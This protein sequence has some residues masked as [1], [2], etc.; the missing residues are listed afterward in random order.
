MTNRAFHFIPVLAALHNPAALEALIARYTPALHALGGQRQDAPDP[1]ADLPH[2][3]F[4]VT[5]GT[6]QRLL[7]LWAQRH[8]IHP[9]EP[10]LLLA[11]P[12]HNALPAAL[13]ILAHLQQ[14][15][16]PGRI[17]YLGGPED[18][19]GLAELAAALDDLAVWRALHQARI[20][21]VGPPSDWLVASSPAPQ[22][23]TDTWGPAVAPLPLERL[24]ALAAHFP[25]EEVAAL[26]EELAAQASATCEPQPADLAAVVRIYLALRELAAAE[27]LTALTLRCFDLVLDH[28]TTGCFALAELNDAGLIAGCEGDLVSTLGMVWAY[29][30]LG[31]LPWMANPARLDVAA[32]T[33]WLAHCTVPRRLVQRYRLRS[34]FE[35][36]LGVGLQGELAPGPV[37]L[38]R[39][40]GAHLRKLWLAEGELLHS[41]NAEDLCRTQAEIQLTRGQ[42][43][44]LLTEPLGNHLVLV[45]GHHAERLH[46]WHRAFIAPQTED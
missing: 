7:D 27:K 20:G 5:G 6:E 45:P 42:V 21:L 38:L 25:T 36:G 32:N 11:H 40:G 16:I 12:G 43:R 31:T 2:L 14:R 1:A 3:Y 29:E 44:E 15:H 39:I 41:G 33:L 13:E 46:H 9:D 37:T 18:S 8:A 34:H 22:R 35:S 10:V 26:A 28:R 19:A 4:I 24:T 30:L 23:L 17:C